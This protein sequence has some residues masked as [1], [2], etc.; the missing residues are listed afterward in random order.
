MRDALPRV[1]R[2]NESAIV[3]LDDTRGSG[4]HWVAY[5]ERGDRVAYFDS[6]GNLRPPR[7]LTR[8]F[9]NDATIT[10]NSI[11]YQTYDQSNC[12]QLCL[13]FLSEQIGQ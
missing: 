13:R 3:N 4:T 9:G 1:V 6:F 8:Y 7:V 5:K 12:G 11:A 10:Y 2:A